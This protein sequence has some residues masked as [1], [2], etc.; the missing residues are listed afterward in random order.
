[1][2]PMRL[3][4]REIHDMK[5]MQEI[6]EEC[7]VVR[8]GSCDEHGMFIVP[9]NFGYVFSEEERKLKLYVHSACEGRNKNEWNRV[10]VFITEARNK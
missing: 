1:M 3:H 8:I 4:K 6:L 5:E 7:K 9:M 10:V 2:Y